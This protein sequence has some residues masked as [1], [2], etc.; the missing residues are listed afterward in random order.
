MTDS[1]RIFIKKAGAFGLLAPL[2][3]HAAGQFF[4]EPEP[5]DVYIFSKHLQFLDYKKSA[6][7]AADIGF[8]GLDLTVRPKGHVLPENVKQDLPKAIA[9]MRKA[10]LS[11]EMITTAI[12]DAANPIDVEVIETAAVEGVKFYRSN[13][14]KYSENQSLEASLDYYQE[15]IKQLGDLNEKHNIVGCYQNH[16]GMSIGA[17]VWEVKK[18]LEAANPQYFGTQYDIRHAVAE[19]GRSWPNGVRLLKNHIKTI[20]LKDFVWDKENGK[21]YIVNVP[22]GE[23]MV[24]FR[25]YFQLLKS[26]GIKPPVSLH[27]EYPL[28]GAEKGSSEIT[29]DQQVVFNAMKKDLSTIQS[30]WK[31]A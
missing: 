27:L 13:W 31:E 5:L 14:Y 29:V 24:D 30:L 28:G 11:C 2:Y 9:E 25:S 21:W 8:K 17:S 4:Q 20:A 23:G 15:K 7:L 18:L 26:Y 12:S 16:S 1:R 19:G 22:I 3:T 10:G 6:E